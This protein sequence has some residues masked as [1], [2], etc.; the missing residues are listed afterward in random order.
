[1]WPWNNQCLK[2]VNKII[3]IFQSKRKKKS[4][5]YNKNTQNVFQIKKRQLLD[6]QI[7]DR[8]N[9]FFAVLLSRQPT[10]LD[11]C[12]KSGKFTSSYTKKSFTDIIPVEC[13]FRIVSFVQ[14][15]TRTYKN[16]FNSSL[17]SYIK[18]SRVGQS[19]GHFS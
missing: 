14:K 2:Y 5:N 15:K 3:I 18:C 17:N 7:L 6:Q 13:S 8:I 16:S 9:I 11:K 19:Y 12:P 1:M 10:T 4:V